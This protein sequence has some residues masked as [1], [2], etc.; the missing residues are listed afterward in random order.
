MIG[1]TGEA[2]GLTDKYLAAI[3]FSCWVIGYT[4]EATVLRVSKS[5]CNSFSC[6]VIGYTGEAGTETGE[7]TGEDQFQLLGDWLYW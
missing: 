5:R 1:Y 3:G 6:W 7:N 4:G 2:Q